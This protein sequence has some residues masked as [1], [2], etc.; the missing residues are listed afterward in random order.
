MQLVDFYDLWSMLLRFSDA[1]WGFLNKQAG[2][3]IWE[4]I[5]GFFPDAFAE[6]VRLSARLSGYMFPEQMFNAIFID[7]SMLE[8][9]LGGGIVFFLGYKFVTWVL[10]VFF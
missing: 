3:F 8:L 5:D 1:A 2:T 4:I 10:D 6:T 7:M 9:I